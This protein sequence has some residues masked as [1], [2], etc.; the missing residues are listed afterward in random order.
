MLAPAARKSPTCRSSSDA[1]ID[2]S[3]PASRAASDAPSEPEESA[4]L[5][6]LAERSGESLELGAEPGIEGPQVGRD[7]ER[8]AAH[9]RVG[10][11]VDSVG[12]EAR[13]GK[14]ALQGLR[15]EGGGVDR[16]APRP[17]RLGE[18]LPRELDHVLWIL[19]ERGPEQT[20]GENH[21]E[22][23]RAVEVSF[24]ASLVLVLHAKVESRRL[25][26][27]LLAGLRRSLSRDT[28]GRSLGLREDR[29]GLE[30]RLREL[31]AYAGFTC[32]IELSFDLAPRVYVFDLRTEW[33]EELSDL[34]DSI[35]DVFEE[36]KSGEE[37]PSGYFSQN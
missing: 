13:N 11:D 15:V 35:D 31:R 25:R 36:N 19:L 14:V 33:F 2:G 27:L 8:A 29:R 32:Q 37:P 6:G 18:G 16:G 28:V 5:K 4:A 22:G 17:A 30:K 1:P 3:G 7:G 23:D 10:V 21:G 24:G 20:L 34:L 12:V 9:G 26:L